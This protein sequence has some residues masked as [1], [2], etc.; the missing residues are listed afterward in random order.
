MF[1]VKNIWEHSPFPK[2]VHLDE[3]SE[4]IRLYVA[5]IAILPKLV[6]VVS[7]GRR[8]HLPFKRR[9]GEEIQ[10]TLREI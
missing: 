3:H 1:E 4:R 6:K 10:A 5:L 7:V 2:A 8:L 9:V